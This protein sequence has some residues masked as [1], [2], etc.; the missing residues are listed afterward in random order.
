MMTRLRRLVAL[1]VLAAA[2][3]ALV[4]TTP[5]YTL[6]GG[7]QSEVISLSLDAPAA[8]RSFSVV[9]TGAALPELDAFLASRTYG[10]V[11]VAFADDAAGVEVALAASGTEEPSA[12]APAPGEHVVFD[13]GEC[14]LLRDC[15]RGV[16]VVVRLAE[17]AEPTD[18]TLTVRSRVYYPASSLPDGASLTYAGLDAP[19]RPATVHIVEAESSG[20]AVLDPARPLDLTMRYTPASATLLRVNGGLIS[21]TY[22]GGPAAG[23]AGASA[24]P[25][26]STVLGVQLQRGASVETVQLGPQ[27]TI[28]RAIAPVSGCFANCALTYR[29]TLTPNPA[30]AHP[31]ARL[32]WRV[33]AWVLAVTEPGGTAPRLEIETAQPSGG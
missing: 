25:G 2:S 13:A 32:A 26:P 23:N 12:F 10:Q 16:D 5:S 19:A 22:A 24:A 4:A 15:R 28:T 11:V 1:G 8:L 33:A 6:L 27:E 14:D 31:D 3:M 30:P 17:G 20:H 7:E 18:V 29:L 9:L 21:G